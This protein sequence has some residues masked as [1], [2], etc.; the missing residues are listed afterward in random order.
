MIN[1]VQIAAAHRVPHGLLR[2]FWDWDTELCCLTC[3]LPERTT[4][5]LVEKNLRPRQYSLDGGLS[6]LSKYK[7][8]S[9]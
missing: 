3:G 7:R 4:T 6:K 1:S 5:L 8:D 9:V 2:P